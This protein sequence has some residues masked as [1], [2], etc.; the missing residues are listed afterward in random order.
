MFHS[1][2]AGGRWHTMS[3][4]EQLG[5]IGSEISRALNWKDKDYIKSLH[6]FYRALEL[7]DLTI[8]YPKLKFRLKEILRARELVCD[9]FIGENEYQSTSAFFRSYFDYF[10]LRAQ[11]QKLIAK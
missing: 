5:N 9:Y 6:A 10:A 4:C 11:Y 3:L 7:F 1:D 8:S 2:L